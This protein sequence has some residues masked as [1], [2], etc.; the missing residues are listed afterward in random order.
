MAGRRASELCG[1][2]PVGGETIKGEGQSFKDA[3][4]RKT[5]GPQALDHEQS[6]EEKERG[7]KPEQKS[8]FLGHHGQFKG[9]MIVEPKGLHKQT[10][11]GML[12]AARLRVRNKR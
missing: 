10:A 4:T 2:R 3:R 12:P 6:K 1:F 11:S 5:E 9:E 7:I 8:K